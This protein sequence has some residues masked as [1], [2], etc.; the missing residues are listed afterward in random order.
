MWNSLLFRGGGEMFKFDIINLFFSELYS[1]KFKKYN[2][3]KSGF[4]ISYKLFFFLA[5]T[6]YITFFCDM[7]NIAFWTLVFLILLYLTKDSFC[8]NN[9]LY[10]IFF[11]I[12]H[13]T[14]IFFLFIVTVHKPWVCFL[15]YLF[16]INATVTQFSK[17]V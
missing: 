12:D 14:C 7:Y 8:I 17:D 4:K 11:V 15:L 10:I 9:L 13:R 1:F 2:S 16:H 6:F 3:Q 5:G